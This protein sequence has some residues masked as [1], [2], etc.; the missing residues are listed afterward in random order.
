M[1]NNNIQTLLGK[2]LE[3]CRLDPDSSYLVDGENCFTFQQ[4][5]TRSFTLSKL[6]SVNNI[7]RPIVVALPRGINAVVSFY[8][9]WLTSNFYVPIDPKWPIE[10]TEYILAELNP[11]AVIHDGSMNNLLNGLNLRNKNVLININDID[12][13]VPTSAL[14][15]I[16]NIIDTSRAENPCYCI[17]TS[18][19]T[20]KPKGVL[21]SNR[22]L[23]N[24]IDWFV[25]EFELNSTSK[26]GNMSQLYFDISAVDI[27]SPIFSG[28]VS[29]FIPDVV[30]KFPID[31]LKFINQKSINSVMWVPSAL[32]NFVTTNVLE[33][34]SFNYLKNIFF[35]GEPLQ[36]KIL[37][38]W[39]QRLPNA[40]FV[41]MYGPTEATITCSHFEVPLGYQLNVIPIG[42]ASLPSSIFLMKASELS[43]SMVGLI[44]IPGE[45][46]EIC[47]GGE[48]LAIGYWADEAKTSE[49]FISNPLISEFTSRIYRTG[50]LGKYDEH[51]NIIFC[52]RLDSQIKYHGYRIEL[53]E[54]EIAVNEMPDILNSVACFFAED[55][56]L[57]LVVEAHNESLKRSEIISYLKNKIPAYM[58][59]S[60]IKVLNKF[61]LLSTGKIDRNKIL[62]E[63][64]SE[65]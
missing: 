37:N 51:G 40:R 56:M 17:Y 63:F 27:Y 58:I 15:D 39:Q 5:L 44:D 52:G 28:G 50:D 62:K 41:N 61:P 38:K 9:S 49:K 48:C 18:G 22:S 65:H 34:N 6:I 57:A 55:S 31:A 7:N 36:V 13:K 46:G 35:A 26:F 33:S 42:K 2:F 59:P 54:I 29:F 11:V 20:G 12:F 45:I 24:Y 32:T 8:A 4:V 30:V 43:D 3:R 60:K 1:Q 53:S 64:L 19:S 21:I 47:I 10:R 25:K 23:F 16:K 14:D